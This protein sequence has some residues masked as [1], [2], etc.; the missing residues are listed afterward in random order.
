MHLV[1]K[2]TRKLLIDSVPDAMLNLEGQ[3]G[4]IAPVAH[5]S[6]QEKRVTAAVTRFSCQ[7][8]CVTAAV[9]HFSLKQK[10]NTEAVERFLSVN[11]LIVKIKIILD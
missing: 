9:M 4:F 11:K 7:E 8:K 6:C 2:W 1:E 10:C 5:F 3:L